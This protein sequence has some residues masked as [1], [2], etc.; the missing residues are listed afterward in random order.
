MKKLIV[1]FALAA[2]TALPVFAGES[3]K[4]K[5]AGGDK[6]KSECQ[7]KSACC[8]GKSS[9]SKSVSKQSFLSPKA[10]ESAK[11]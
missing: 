9:C 1:C 11:K 7:A 8:N 10:A 3:S 6:A 5:T 4:D 2:V